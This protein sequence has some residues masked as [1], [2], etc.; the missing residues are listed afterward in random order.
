MS[1]IPPRKINS[2]DCVVYVGRKTD[3]KSITEPGTPYKIHETE[4][5]EIN[6]IATI[7]QHLTIVELQNALNATDIK[8][9]GEIFEKI[10][11]LIADKIISWNWTD[12]DNQPLPNPYRNPSVIKQLHEDEIAW[13]LKAIQGETPGERKNA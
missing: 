11:K 3:G 12:N 13:L 5:V 9:I 1:K 4:W 10:C 6:S 7:E 8:T 2:D